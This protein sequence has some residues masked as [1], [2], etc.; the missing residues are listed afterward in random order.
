M[1]PSLKLF[2]EINSKILEIDNNQI[3]DSIKIIKNT[4]KKG[5]K[6][7]LAGNGASS[8][9][10]S[11][12]AVDFTKNT[13]ARAINFN[14]TDL[15][16][17]FSNDFG[18]ENWI[19]KSLEYYSDH[20]DLVILISSSGNSLNIVKAAKY[21]KKN[22]L[23]LITLSGMNWKNKISNLGQVNFWVN[24]KSYNAIETVHQAILLALVEYF[25][26]YK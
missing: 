22:K 8:A 17:C 12:V 23:K 24:S 9:I 4:I 14:E 5:N 13:R 3:S 2:K 11:H 16:T 1:I 20:N 19:K 10:A 7:I 21:C 6:I 15:I 26:T 18:Y 25:M